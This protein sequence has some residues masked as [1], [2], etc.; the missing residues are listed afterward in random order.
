MN[1][2]S[3]TKNYRSLKYNCVLAFLRAYDTWAVVIFV[4]R[5]KGYGFV[6]HTVIALLLLLAFH[7]F[8]SRLSL[9]RPFVF[10]NL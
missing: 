2:F 7:C 1:K 3:F 10:A 8:F 5:P 6:S 4:Y 9:I